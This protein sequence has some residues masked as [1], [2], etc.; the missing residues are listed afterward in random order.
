M[1]ITFLGTSHGVPA[2][3][4]FCS[5]TMIETGDVYYLIDA[6]APAV[7][8]LL[9][10]DKKIEDLRAVFTTHAHTDHTVGLIHLANLMEW[11]YTKSSADFYITNEPQIKAYEAVMS[12]SGDCREYKFSDRVRFHVTDIN[13]PYED[14]N[15]KLT[16]FPTKH[17]GNLPS[18]SI[19]VE[20]K[21]TGK[22]VFFSGDFNG[23]LCDVPS[24]L[25]EEEYDIFVCEM[26]HFSPAALK[27]YLDT[28]KSKN[29]YFTHVFPLSKY[30]EIEKFKDVYSF[31]IFTP[32]DGDSV[33]V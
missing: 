28:C 23:S 13:A 12:A 14:E 33:E 20:E 24:V 25:S 11:Y 30:D 7:D 8:L 22:R 15:I 19:L 27:P 6:G 29:V 31:G 1:K 16:Y 3:D 32:E 21:A 2:K 5:C 9:R 17:M 10:N 26:A 4:R 18:Y